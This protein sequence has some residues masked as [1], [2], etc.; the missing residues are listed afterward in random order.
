METIY[1]VAIIGAG[2]AGLSAAVYTS[3]AG[4]STVI[5]ER[6][7]PGG[8]LMNTLELEN[9]PGFEETTGPE[10]GMK[11]SNHATKFGAIHKYGDVKEIRIENGGG[12]NS[13]ACSDYCDRNQISN[14]W[15]SR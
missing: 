1:D 12:R 4:L 11:L 14:A 6:G 7:V 15:C 8:Q 3:R 9:Y 10:L 5:I 2:P 13:C